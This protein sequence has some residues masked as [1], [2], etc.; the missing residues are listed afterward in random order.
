MPQCP[1]NIKLAF[2]N[3]CQFDCN[4]DENDWIKR[5]QIKSF[6]REKSPP[7]TKKYSQFCALVWKK[8]EGSELVAMMILVIVEVIGEVMDVFEIVIDD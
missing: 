6:H 3:H 1:T 7:K 5:K 8:D 4:M 2:L